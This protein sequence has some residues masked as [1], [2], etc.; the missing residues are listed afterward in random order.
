QT[1]DMP[2]PQPEPVQAPTARIVEMRRE[3]EAPRPA[4]AA[5]QPLGRGADVVTALSQPAREV[6][7][8]ATQEAPEP[9]VQD[10]AGDFG[11]ILSDQARKQVAA[12][13]G[14]LSD[15]FAA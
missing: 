2:Q 10:A 13:F 3:T 9:A 14:E 4:V 6:A 8:A 7:P 12:S 5:A 15:A 11:S 1:P